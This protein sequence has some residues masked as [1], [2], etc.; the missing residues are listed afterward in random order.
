MAD[1]RNPDPQHRSTFR[2]GAWVLL[3]VGLTVNVAGSLGFL[4]LAAGVAGGV[5]VAVAVA[6]LVRGRRRT[7][8][9]RS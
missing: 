8:R 1:R 5:V 7:R 4:P 6:G 2:A 3:L 9:T